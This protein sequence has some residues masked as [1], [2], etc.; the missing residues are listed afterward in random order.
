MKKLIFFFL[1]FP[2]WGMAQ[3]NCE[4]TVNEID[5]FTGVSRLSNTTV[6]G[7]DYSGTCSIEFSRTDSVFALIIIYQSDGIKGLTAEQRHHSYFKFHDGEILKF[8][9][10][11]TSQSKFATGNYY[12]SSWFAV[13]YPIEKENELKK[14]A[15]KQLSKL[16]FETTNGDFDF[17]VDKKS[18]IK[19]QIAAAC[20]YKD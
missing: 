5:E 2:L 14:F 12:A 4:W 19:L 11:L 8:K 10:I 9:N 6:V 7:R 18:A 13:G 1:L 20:L 17:E 16:R 3:N 15:S